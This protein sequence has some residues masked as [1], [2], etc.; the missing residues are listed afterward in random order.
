M[1]IPSLATLAVAAII[2]PSV[3]F[4]SIG[5]G[6]GSGKIV[7]QQP[8]KPGGLYELPALPVLNTGDEPSEYAVSIEYN[9]TQ[10][11]LKP[12]REWFVFSPPTFHLDPRGSK[13][14][15]LSL[16]IPLKA[17]PGEYFAYVEA[18][19]IKKAIPGQTGV[20]IAAAAKLYFTVAPANIFQGMYYRVV[21]FLMRYA[22]WTYV[23]L[24]VV[25]A[26]VLINILR[27]YVSFSVGIRKD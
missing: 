8:L 14:V 18:H 6:V 13:I 15:G 11:Q 19:P 3:A 4:A 21:T 24:G 27:R 1:R 2:L 20:G 26:A 10:P 25:A 23:V 12:A 9:E 17:T 7:V 5:V 22:P 16:S